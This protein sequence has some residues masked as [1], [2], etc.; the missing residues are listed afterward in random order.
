MPVAAAIVLAGGRSSRMGSPKAT[1]EWHG[2]TL[3]RRVTGIMG[4]AV[5]GPVIVVRAPDQDLPDLDPAVEVVEDAREGRGPMQGLAAGLAAVG[6]RA[7]VAYVSAT[8]VPLLHPAFVRRVVAS[9]GDDADIALPDVGGHRQPLAAAYRVKLAGLV[10][11]LVAAGRLRPAFLFER[12]RVHTLDEA[13]LL[14]DPALARADPDLVSVM[15]LNEPGDYERAHALPPPQIE[16]DLAA[17]APGGPEWRRRRAWSLGQLAAVLGLDLDR[18]VIA[19]INGGAAVSDPQL[20]L[21]AGD[22]VAFLPAANPPVVV[23]WPREG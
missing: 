15:N 4:R 11:E 13:A 3:L 23:E 1:L 12:S 16:A 8:D 10:C 18:H 6:D 5:D 2:S 14:A 22:H 21:V 7:G 9:L 17:I 20:P 19:E